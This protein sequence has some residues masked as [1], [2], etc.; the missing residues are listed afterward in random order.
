MITFPVMSNVDPSHVSASR[1]SC[2]NAMLDGFS[3]F[4][5]STMSS[6][7]MEIPAPVSIRIGMLLCLSISSLIHALFLVMLIFALCLWVSVSWTVLHEHTFI[8]LVS[9]LNLVQVGNGYPV[10]P[11]QV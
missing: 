2:T 3:L 9:I 7:M 10:V 11:V 8:V 1:R 6:R 5:S 4:H